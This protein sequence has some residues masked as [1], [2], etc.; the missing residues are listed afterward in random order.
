MELAGEISS[1]MS[2]VHVVTSSSPWRNR[3]NLERKSRSV[4]L[5]I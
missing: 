4:L 2:V 5:G 1:E 3:L